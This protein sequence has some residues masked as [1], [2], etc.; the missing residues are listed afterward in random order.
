M[1]KVAAITQTAAALDLITCTSN[2]F[3][4]VSCLNVFHVVARQHMCVGMASSNFSKLLFT[5]I[6]RHKAV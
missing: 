2:L 5:Q 6:L 1:E 3:D 4:Y